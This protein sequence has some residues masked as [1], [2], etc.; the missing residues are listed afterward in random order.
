MELFHSG[1]W[2]VVSMLLDA[3]GLPRQ[4]TLSCLLNLDIFK[5]DD[6]IRLSPSVPNTKG[7]IWSE[8]PNPYEAWEVEIAFKVTGNNMHGG[9][10]LAFWY[11]KDREETGPVF[12]SKDQWDGLSV[13]LDSANPVVGYNENTI[14][15]KL[16]QFV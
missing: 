1:Q 10:G 11:T 6:F 2:A 16:S 13:W 3:H 15:V 12:G 8:I 5:S 7:F 9:R 14:D 4:P